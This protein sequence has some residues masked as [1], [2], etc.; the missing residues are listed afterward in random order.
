MFN[1]LF[2][3][4]LEEGAQ[5]CLLFQGIRTLIVLDLDSAL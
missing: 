2:V 1:D 5:G 4:L 3:F